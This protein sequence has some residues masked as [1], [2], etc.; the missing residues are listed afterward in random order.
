[1]DTEKTLLTCTEAEK[2]LGV[3]TNTVREWRANKGLPAVRLSRRVL[4]PAKAIDEW[5]ARQ[6]E[7]ATA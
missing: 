7:V 4:Y 5:L 2:K 1:M 3:S 6:L